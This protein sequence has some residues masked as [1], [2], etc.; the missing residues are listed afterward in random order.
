[1]ADTVF[2]RELMRLHINAIESL[3]HENRINEAAI[4]AH[5]NAMRE[6]L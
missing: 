1:M 3:M 4:G 5:L 2:D 6:L